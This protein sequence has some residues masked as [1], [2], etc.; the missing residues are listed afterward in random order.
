MR[1]ESPSWWIGAS[2]AATYRDL[3]EPTP[4]GGAATRIPVPRLSPRPGQILITGDVA[5]ERVLDTAELH[6][7][8]GTI[9]EVRYATRRCCE[10]HLVQG[11][12]LHEVLA[13]TCPLLDKRHKMGRLNVIVLVMSEDGY[14]VVRSLAE[15]DPEFG[16]CAALL[17]T[18]YNGRVLT[19]PTLVMPHDNRAS[20]YVRDLCHLRLL[21]VDPLATR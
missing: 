21:S 2:V 13:E 5:V 12:P 17:A 8:A 18:R 3:V 11:V 20:R 15:I 10:M 6:A 19:R 4:T 14:Q 1:I 16:A 7:R 9:H